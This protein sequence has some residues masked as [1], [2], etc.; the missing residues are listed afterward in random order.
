[1]AEVNYIPYYRYGPWDPDKPQKFMYMI[2]KV[3]PKDGG[4]SVVR[5]KKSVMNLAALHIIKFS[6]KKF[7]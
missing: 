7:F 2:L 5:K 6:P 3:R 1:V 4:G